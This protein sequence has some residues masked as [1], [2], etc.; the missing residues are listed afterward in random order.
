[1]QDKLEK[2]EAL[3]TELAPGVIAVSGGLDSRFLADF[4]WSLNLEFE[5][6]HLS[7]PH[8]ALAET[9]AAAR[10]LEERGKPWLLLD[11]NPLMDPLVRGSDRERCY[12]C[13]RIA[14]STIIEEIGGPEVLRSAGGLSLL[15]GTQASDATG[16]RP[17]RRALAELGVRSPL[18]EAGLTKPEIRELARMAGLE[19][20]DRPARPCLLTR[21][22]YG[23]AVDEDV[24]ADLSVAEEAIARLGI[25]EFRLRVLG[26]PDCPE[27]VLQIA[28]GEAARFSVVESVV[29]DLPELAP[30]PNLSVVVSEQ[31]S[32]WFDAE[33]QP[34]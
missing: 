31:V 15:D 13:K 22:A 27:H 3:L 34:D 29:L 7:G 2:L 6:I 25:R 11:V 23:L 12:R 8:I 16:Y 10:W 20:W 18:A 4:A 9:E 5:A 17:G 26:T 21:F 14:F 1:M 19:G 32:G 24:L 33:A 30:F 28:A